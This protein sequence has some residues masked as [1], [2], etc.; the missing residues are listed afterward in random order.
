MST[1]F[2]AWFAMAG[3]GSKPRPAHIGNP[4]LPSLHGGAVGALAVAA[5]RR[6]LAG[7]ARV[8]SATV[9]YLRPGRAD[10][11]TFAQAH[12]VHSGR[13]FATVTVTVEQEAEDGGRRAIAS[14][15][16]TLRRL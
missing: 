16:L 6:A 11:P 5:G 7:D 2:D 15:L 9:S 1:P 3:D 8:V 13:R 12:L 14:A 4:L 10:W